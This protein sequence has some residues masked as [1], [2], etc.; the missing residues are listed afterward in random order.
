MFTLCKTQTQSPSLQAAVACIGLE[1][2]LTQERQQAAEQAESL[3]AAQEELDQL[4]LTHQSLQQQLQV[5]VLN[6]QQT[7]DSLEE[8][9]RQHSQLQAE[10]GLQAAQLIELRA[11]LQ[12]GAQEAK[13]VQAKLIEKSSS[14][15]GVTVALESWL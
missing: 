4:S 3:A 6:L 7:Q 2:E 9:V 11:E 5:K 12:A 1:E 8:R 13:S 14:I 10:S 15:S